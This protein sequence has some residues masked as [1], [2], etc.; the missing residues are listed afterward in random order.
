M[1]FPKES[2][3]VLAEAREAASA[4]PQNPDNFDRKE[5]KRGSRTARDRIAMS[6]LESRREGGVHWYSLPEY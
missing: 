6:L 2:N 1:Q 5:R 4:Y 3:Q